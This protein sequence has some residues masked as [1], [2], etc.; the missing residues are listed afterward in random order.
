MSGKLKGKHR[1]I[2]RELSTGSLSCLR[3]VRSGCIIRNVWGLTSTD[4][5]VTAHGVI[6]S[7]LLSV[8]GHQPY[9]LDPGEMIPIVV[10]ARKR[11]ANT[12]G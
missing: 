4:I 11:K 3:P 2:C 8:I 10:K 12:I 6:S 9:N 5:S 1:S 7:S